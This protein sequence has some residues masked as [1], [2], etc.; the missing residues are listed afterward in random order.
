MAVVL[1]TG[2]SSGFGFA[3]AAAFGRAGDRVYATVRDRSKGAALERLAA[4]ERIDIRLIYLELTDVASFPS[5]VN[6]IVK[7]AGRIDVLVNNAGIHRP[8]AFEDLD[9]NA[10]REVLETNFFAPLLLARSVLPQMRSQRSGYII[11]ISSLS[12]IAG[13]PADVAYTASKFALEGATEALRHEVDRWRIKVALVE[14]GMYATGLFAKN[15]DPNATLPFNYPSSSPYRA[16]VEYRMRERRA[17]L[18][19]AFD[20]NTLAALLVDIPKSDGRQLRWPADARAKSIIATVFGQDDAA[21]DRFLRD[22]SGTDWW[23]DGGE[24]PPP[25]VAEHS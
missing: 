9:E 18:P 24:P 14:A 6:S 3:S 20:P 17:R 22:V 25:A 23:S 15:I 12:G 16:L 7:D 2:C 5:V 8:G 21:R 10:L 11:M 19:H 13:L 4:T 1:I